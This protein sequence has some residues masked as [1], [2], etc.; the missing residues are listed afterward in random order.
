MHRKTK[1]LNANISIIAINP[2][3]INVPIKI[4]G[5]SGWNLKI[6]LYSVKR[7][8]FIHFLIFKGVAEGENLFYLILF[9]FN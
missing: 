7:D 9:K 2:N 1:D 5:L 4:Q 3:K 8:I 6:Q